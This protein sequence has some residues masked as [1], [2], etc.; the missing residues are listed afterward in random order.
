MQTSSTPQ[1]PAA[2]IPV[3]VREDRL[4]AAAGIAAFA[5]MLVA[6]FLLPVDQ[7]G[8]SAA[9]IASR[10]SDG[11]EGYLR[12]AFAEG[13]S[14]AFLVVFLGGLRNAIARAEGRTRTFSS[15]VAIGGSVAAGLQ[16]VGY[17]LIA[18]LA[19]R[20]AGTA[21]TDVVTAFYDASSIASAFSFFGLAV[22][23]FAAGTVMVRTG[24]ISRVLGFAGL[25]L[26]VLSLVTAGSLEEDGI[27]SLHTGIGFLALMFLY[28]WVLV[29]GVL[30]LRPR[31]GLR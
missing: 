1:A 19:Y 13:L 2:R 20:T 28:V 5:A 11:S 17:A 12:A 31:H 6:L 14:V 26:G 21:D 23:L 30:M 16:L 4:A 18:T 29:A 25:V 10:Y 3:P 9:D 24:A 7:G 27:L 22:L 15:A 8:Q